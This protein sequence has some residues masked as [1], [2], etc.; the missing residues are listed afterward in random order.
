VLNAGKAEWELKITRTDLNP[1]TEQQTGIFQD[2]PEM[3]FHS[4]Y[5]P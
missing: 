5:M 1:D 2:Y 4:K 3:T